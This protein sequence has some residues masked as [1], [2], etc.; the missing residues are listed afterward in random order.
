M[1]CRGVNVLNFSDL[2][3]KLVTKQVLLDLNIPDHLALVKKIYGTYY[4]Y[5]QIYNKMYS[6]YKGDTDAM[7]KYK[8]V[9]E[10]SNLKINTNYIKKFIKEEVSYTVG[11][12]ITYESRSDDSN[13]IKDIEYY[14]I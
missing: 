3:K 13:I 14:E 9:T 1:A 4:A 12:E 10:R 8:F 2:I 6:Y 7:S 11:N 5:K